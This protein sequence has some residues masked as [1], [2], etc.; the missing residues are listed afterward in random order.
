MSVGAH[1]VACRGPG[2]KGPHGRRVPTHRGRAPGWVPA[3]SVEVAG[4]TLRRDPWSLVSEGDAGLQRPGLHLLDD[5]VDLGLDVG[6]DDRLEVVERREAG[7]AEGLELGEV[8][9]LGL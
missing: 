5:L 8:A 7:L 4:V 2:A 3:P 9:V 6:R 1:S